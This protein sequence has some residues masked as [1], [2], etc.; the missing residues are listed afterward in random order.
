VNT[1]YFCDGASFFRFRGAA[2]EAPADEV[3]V[4]VEPLAEVDLGCALVIY[5]LLVWLGYRTSKDAES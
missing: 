2:A 3:D 4:V 1:S 5:V